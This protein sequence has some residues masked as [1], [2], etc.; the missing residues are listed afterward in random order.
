MLGIISPKVWPDNAGKGRKDKKDPSEKRDGREPEREDVAEK[1]CE[2]IM[3]NDRRRRRCI[4]PHRAAWLSRLPRLFRLSRLSRLSE[5]RGIFPICRICRIP[6]IWQISVARFSIFR[7]GPR[8]RTPRSSP[9]LA[10]PHG[11]WESVDEQRGV[12]AILFSRKKSRLGLFLR[13][14]IFFFCD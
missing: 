11:S 10:V 2:S 4:V 1:S 7:I 3:R 6:R 9:I 12:L 8:P 14:V 13:T 5:I